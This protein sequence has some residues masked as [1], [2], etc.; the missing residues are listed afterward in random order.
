MPLEGALEH[1]LEHTLKLETA[2]SP[3]AKARG[4]S[5]SE[6]VLSP[7]DIPHWNTSAMDGYAVRAHD[8]QTSAS[9][10]ELPSCDSPQ[11]HST[12]SYTLHIIDT[13]AAGG[14]PSRELSPGECAR[15]MTGAPIPPGADAVLIQEQCRREG[16]LLH[17]SS[18][19]VCGQNIR[20]RGEELKKGELGLPRGTTLDAGAI[21]LCAGLGL[22]EVKTYRPPR[23]GVLSTGDELVTPGHE[24]LPGQ[25][26]SSNGIALASLIEEAGAI[27]VP[28][29][30]CRDTE[31]DL[32]EAIAHAQRSNLDVLITT[33]GVSV[34]DHDLVK[35]A[36]A[37]AGMTLAFWKLRLK[38]GKPLAFGTLGTMPVFGLPGNP[39]SCMVG[40]LQFVRPLIR[41]SL[42]DPCPFLPVVPARFMDTWSR[43]PGR[44]ELLRVSLSSTTD[45]LEARLCGAQGSGRISSMARAQGL[46]LVHHQAYRLKPG[47][48]IQVQ[49]LNKDTIWQPEP[50]Y[51]WSGIST[52]E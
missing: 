35:E 31:R 24:L 14:S 52:E 18:P 7:C 17:S 48:T 9:D 49:L 36:L 21:G 33:G 3:L 10:P 39:V 6:P 8:C 30:I 1:V 42:H 16:S 2:V 5:L 38:P 45:G 44:N 27:P 50:M 25:I 51:I 29:G 23:V 15:I 41:T 22:S 40:F 43:R 37:S 34:G 28:L 12:T 19:V 46:A 4:L 26:W 20:R 47:D 13:I 11:V 32:A